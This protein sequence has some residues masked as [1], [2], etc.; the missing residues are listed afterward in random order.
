MCK[1]IVPIVG[2]ESGCMFVAQMPRVRTYSLL[3]RIVVIAVFEHLFVVVGFDD[4]IV[5]SGDIVGHVARD[6]AQVGSD[7]QSLIVEQDRIPHCIAC[8]VAYRE[9]LYDEVSDC[10]FVAFTEHS[11]VVALGGDTDIAVDTVEDSLRSVDGEVVF[12]C[13]YTDVF[14]VVG[15]GVGDEYAVNMAKVDT[16]VF[17]DLLD[18]THTYSRIDKE[19]VIGGTDEVTITAT[20]AT[21]A[22]KTKLIICGWHN[23]S[24]STYSFTSKKHDKG[25]KNYCLSVYT[26]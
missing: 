17:A 2:E 24:F 19:T 6:I 26:L 21:K 20:A 11:A 15:M 3:E 25:T 23:L 1:A 4:K 12:L 16:V 8:I 5:G 14:D 13:Q 7:Y 18:R 10:D 9:R 22:Q